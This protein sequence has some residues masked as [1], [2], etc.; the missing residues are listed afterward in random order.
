MVTTKG[1]GLN[2]N[3][4]VWQE[5]PADQ[6]NIPE[7][8]DDAPWLLTYPSS[9]EMTDG[10]S[11]L[12]SSEGKGFDWELP[13]SAA[14]Y[15]SIPVDGTEQ[16]DL[17]YLV[18]DPQFEPA[19]DGNVPSEQPVS[20]EGVREALQKRLEFCFSRE[21]LSKDLYLMSQMDSDNFVPIWAVAC[22]EDIKA[23]TADVDLIVDVLRASPMVQ[24]DESGKKVRP[25]H[26]RCI[27]IL[28]EV[29]ETTPVEEVEALF[30][31]DNCP[32]VLSA[33]FA[34]NSNWYITFQSDMDAQQAFRYLREEVKTFQGKPIMARIKAI[35]TFFG[36]NGFCNV[37][38]SVYY[39]SA[40]QQAQYGSPV[41]IQQVYDPQQ[42]QYPVYPVVSPSWNPSVMPY[43]ESS[44]APYPNSGFINAY[45]SPGSYKGNSLRERGGQDPMF[46]NV[47]RS[48]NHVKSH[49]KPGDVPPSALTPLMDA[50]PAT[51]SPQPLH[52]E[53]LT[54]TTPVSFSIPSFGLREQTP[55]GGPSAPVFGRRG[56]QRNTRRNREEEHPTRPAP[57]MKA[58][59]PESPKFDLAASNF[60]PLPGSAVSVQGET[61]T[62]MRLSDV[63]RGMKATSK[64]ASKEANKAKHVNPCDAPAGKPDP[65]TAAACSA[66][67]ASSQS[68]APAPGKEEEVAERPA[69]K[70][71]TPSS[72]PSPPPAEHVHAACSQSTP[73]EAAASSLTDLT[74][75]LG[76]KKLSYAQVCQKLAKDPPPAN[77]PSPTPPATSPVQ[78]LQEVKVNRV[79]EE[80]RPR[81]K[82][83]AE[84]PHKS[85]DNRP[86]RQP[87]HSLKGTNN[88]GRFA[89][90]A[91]RNREYHRGK[92]FS[93]RQGARWSGK[94][95]N[96]PPRSPK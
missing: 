15:A 20:G 31:G 6:S 84:R 54:G 61:T 87:L 90:P 44:M 49:P 55:S 33:E 52:S 2:P 16:T 63:V 78:P 94:E 34:H 8:T 86:P 50:L 85:G 83:S 1:A 17:S 58:A 73:T 4:K 22:M 76:L 96:I 70:A 12:T 64:P 25:N 3:A 13:D 75:D 24:V 23:L 71:A 39:Q 68:S 57:L 47:N 40:Q 5:I 60:P 93:P 53:S 35:N 37:D 11:S 72:T 26:S 79:V 28:R 45:S 65:V 30:K 27:I 77:A 74:P 29:P 81:S 43:F 14:D 95:Q 10:S 38:S 48:R 67:A 59:A 42:Q 7:W 91:A 9:T 19:A 21:N 62:E 36:K 82:F 92:T 88:Q 56:N 51:L 18:L 66:P 69:S 89:G 32:K 80:P 41:F 46:R